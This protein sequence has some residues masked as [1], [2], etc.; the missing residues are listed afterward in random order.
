MP[1]SALLLVLFAAICHTTWNLLLKRDSR[2]LETQVGA[3]AWGVVLASPVLAV[4][5]LRDVSPTGWVLIAA[6]AVFE[7]RRCSACSSCESPGRRAGS[8]PLS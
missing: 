5:S 3:L 8:S 7:K 1:A 2:R 4:Y 6:S